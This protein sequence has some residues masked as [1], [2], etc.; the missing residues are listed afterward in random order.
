MRKKFLKYLPC[1][2]TFL[3]FFV[4]QMHA[5]EKPNIVL[6]LTDD[7]PWNEYGFMGSKSAH[8]P[9]IDTLAS[10]SVRFVNGYVTSS[11]CRPSLGVLLTGLYPHQSGIWFNAS[12]NRKN[13]QNAVHLIQNLRSLPRLLRQ[14]GYKS[15][16]T[17]KHWEGDYKEAGFDS[18]TTVYRAGKR[19]FNG[20]APDGQKIGRSTL[21]PIYDFVNEQVESDTPFFLWYGVYLPHAPANAPENYRKIFKEKG[22][23]DAEIAY[24]ANIAWLDD[25]IGKLMSFFDQ[26][27]ISENTLFILIS[28]NGMTIHQ[29]PWWG[30]AGGKTSTGEMGLRSPIL[31]RWDKKINPGTHQQLVSSIDILPTILKAAGLRDSDTYLS[32]FSGKDLMQ[33][34]KQDRSTE[35]RPVFGALYNPNPRKVVGFS[36]DKAVAYQ[37]VRKGDYKLIVPQNLHR[38]HIIL[39]GWPKITQVKKEDHFTE[40]R[41]F[42]LKDDPLEKNNLAMDPVFNN[43][44]KELIQLINSWW[45]VATKS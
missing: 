17:G 5:D 41:L 44:K 13:D 27:G 4:L 15:L 37:W 21:K 1:V 45:T 31:M 24:H 39:Q 3:A 14:A 29:D 2:F 16:Q 35:E 19:S 40:I 23:S 18:G 34:S 10:Q 25:T 6:L 32:K 36:A 8:T 9:N 12:P 7:H 28:D 33:L 20:T 26:K 11:V 38:R 22:L 30:G 43:K 42:N